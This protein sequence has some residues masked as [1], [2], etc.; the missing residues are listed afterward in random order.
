[1]SFSS[2]YIGATGVVAHNASMQVV[3]N[4]LANVST[5]GYKRADAQFGT[6][7]SQQ[8]GTS[9]VQY[10][11]G[12]HGMSQ[13]G[14]GVAVSEIRTIFKDGPLASTNTATDLAISGQGFFGTRNVSDSPAGASHYTR[15]G[16]FRFN[17]DSFLVDANDYRLQGYAINRGTGEVA[18]TISDIHLPYEDVNVDGQ[19]TRL[20]RSEPLATSSVEM[21]TNLDHSAADLFADT[22]NPMFSML[23]AYSANQSNASTPFGATLPEYSS[24]ITVY[25]ENG[26]DHEMTVYFDPISTNTLSNAVPGYTYWE[27]LVAMPPESDGSSAY[28]TSGAGLA[29]VGVLTFNDQGHLVG[30]AAY[31]LDS[32]LSSN[33]AGTNLDSWVPSTFNEDGLPEISY[34]FGSNGGTV[35]ASKTISYDFGINSDSATWLSGAGSPATIGTDVKALAQMDDM[36]RDAR[37]STSYDSPSATM[38][39]IQDGYSWG[40][41][42][43]VSVNDEGILTGYFSNNKSEALYQ[44]AV[45]RFNSPWG[46]DRAGQTNFTASPDSGAAIDGVAKDKGRG[47]ILDS[48]LEESNVDMAQEFANMILTQRGFQANTKVISTSDS[49][50]NTLISIKR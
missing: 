20:V 43:N 6:L 19:I 37:V 13:M 48:S 25:D 9:G 32:A 4:N 26:D 35:G 28:G 34:T 8:L 40:Y 42:R 27:Y 7:M 38:Y 39:H 45:Y 29:G 44:V 18:T 17:N 50:L 16:A 1:M 21:V 47:T 46:L 24:G 30:Q 33:A 31:S 10:Q 5:T 11:S 22:D 41:L 12:S 15:A 23:Q 14:K 3:A 2:M 36:N 49:L